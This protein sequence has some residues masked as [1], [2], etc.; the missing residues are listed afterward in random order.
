MP[1]KRLAPLF[2]LDLAH[3][4]QTL[5]PGEAF[6]TMPHFRTVLQLR[7]HHFSKATIYRWLKVPK[8]YLPTTVQRILSAAPSLWYLS[9]PENPEWTSVSTIVPVRYLAGP[10]RETAKELALHYAPPSTLRISLQALQTHLSILQKEVDR[11]AQ[12][13][14]TLEGKDQPYAEHGTCCHPPSA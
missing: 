12:H 2:T 5:A 10:A 7:G 9:I 1:K 11:L 13:C 3:P 6:L 14:D 4:P 8:E